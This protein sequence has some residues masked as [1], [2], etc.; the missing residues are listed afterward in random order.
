MLFAFAGLQPFLAM[1]PGGMPRA[2]EVQLDWRVL[3]FAVGTSLLCGFLFGLAPALRA[4]SRQLEE[5][6][7][8]LL[9]IQT[10]CAADSTFHVHRFDAE[11]I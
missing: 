1:W 9:K 2:E 8:S 7:N 4:P 3:L 6:L 10:S 5:S 11:T